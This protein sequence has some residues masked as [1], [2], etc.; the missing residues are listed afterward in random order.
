MADS[1]YNGLVSAQPIPKLFTVE[2]YEQIPD[3]PG[4]HYEL[5]HEELVFETF[6]VR[7]HKDLQR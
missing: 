6:S 1:I 7:Q 5:H 3:P 4:G 2:E